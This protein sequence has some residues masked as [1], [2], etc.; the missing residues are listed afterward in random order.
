MMTE[1]DVQLE[2]VRLH[3]AEGPKNGP[4]LVLIPGQSMPWES[5][6]K[7]IPLL[8]GRFHVF[9]IDVRGHGKSEHTP[10]RYTFATCGADLV[11]FLKQVVG[12]PAIC[13]GNSSGGLIALWAAA[14]QPSLVRAVL[15]ED[16]P[17]FSAEWPRMRDQTWVHQ[18]FAHVVNTLPDLAKFFGTL[19][20]PTQGSKKLISAP[21]PLTWLLGWAIA[22][23]LRQFPGQP[24]D[25]SWLPLQMRLFVRGLSEYDVDFT[26]ACVDGRMCDMN[27][28]GCLGAVTCPVTLVQAASFL[29]ANGL[30]VS[31]MSDADVE[32]AQSILP[33]LVVE[34]L[35][36]PHV[37]HIAKPKYFATLVDQLATRS[38]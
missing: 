11:Q 24:V 19:K 5:Y 15:L 12:T 28:A 22:R 14:Q 17:L 32:Q 1:K 13:S 9:A 7:A 31:A 2:G 35:N 37:V 29:D 36:A 21:R 3:Y 25:L 6:Q 34:R 38:Q 8:E 4:A 18:F 20:V 26:R 30:L 33:G 16:P 27:H 10:G 23:R